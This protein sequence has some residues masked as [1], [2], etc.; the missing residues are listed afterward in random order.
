MPETTDQKAGPS[1]K[2]GVTPSAATRILNERLRELDINASGLP[3][4]VVAHLRAVVEEEAAAIQRA[5]VAEVAALQHKADERI[6]K[7]VSRT[8][9]FKSIGKAF[10]AATTGGAAKPVAAAQP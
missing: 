5:L 6:R 1:D 4:H 9:T 2:N 10:A 3:P 7:A 8:I